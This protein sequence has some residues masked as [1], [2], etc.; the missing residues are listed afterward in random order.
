MKRL[1]GCSTNKFTK[2]VATVG[3]TKE[4]LLDDAVLIAEFNRG[5]KSVIYRV[6][7]G[8]CARLRE[9]VP[10]VKV[11]RYNPKHLY[12]ELDGYGDNGERSLKV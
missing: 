3:I 7:R 1:K 9:N 4:G 12:P 8:D 5:E 6:S 10:Y 11:H 2:D